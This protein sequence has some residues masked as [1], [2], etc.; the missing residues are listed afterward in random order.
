MPITVPRYEGAQVRETAI[1]GTRVS[2]DLP[3]AAVPGAGFD[4]AMAPAM[5]ML[6]KAKN[7]ADQLAIMEADKKLTQLET[8]L[9]YNKQTG[10]LN[11][12]GKDSFGTPDE[13][14][15]NY[16]KSAKDIEDSLSNPQQKMAFQRI[17]NDRGLSI[18]RTVQKHVA[19]EIK[20]YDDNETMAY[21][22]TQRDLA[23][24]A[25]KD[26]DKINQSIE[27]QKIAI[28]AHAQR[29]GMPP[30]WVKLKTEEAQSKTHTAV[31]ERM[32]GGG[33][34]MAAQAYFEANKQFIG[35]Q[36]S[37]KLEHDLKI[38][39]LAGESQRISDKIY[40]SGKSMSESIDEAKKIDDPKLRD[41]TIE[42]IKDN[43]N[44]K[45]IADRDAAEKTSMNFTNMIDQGSSI[46]DIM[47]KSPRQWAALPE[48]E[49]SSLKRYY[50]HAT[51]GKA[52]ETDYQQY[53]DLKTL[54]SSKE[55]KDEFLQT[56]IMQ[57]RDKLGNTELKELMALQAGMRK[58]DEKSQKQLD[59]YRTDKMIVDGA[60]AAAGFDTSLKGR[61]ADKVVKFQRMVDD[62]ITQLQDK[63]GKKANNA[64]VQ[65]ITDNLMIEVVTNKGF[66]WDT[67]KRAFELESGEDVEDLVIA[68]DERRK[69]EDALKR[70]GVQVSDKAVNEM[71]L[72]KMRRGNNA[73]K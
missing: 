58:G 24:T 65:K 53:Y 37:A 13:V 70:G 47:Q 18:D 44:L 50:E 43:F 56:N 54:A 33:E 17:A 4:K 45:K 36:E 39:T 30:E 28:A 2:T 23:I 71:Y 35:G 72:K 66:F 68:K 15:Q 12:R 31:V 38:S 9:L 42:R 10:A 21:V 20:A 61:D 57:Y 3:A 29:N 63:T 51:S 11:K 26:P 52:I 5:D 25:Y 69:I 32:I 73:S 22:G 48:S 60:L 16:S 62:Q 59:G 27:S 46:N 67:K 49:R 41:A 14:N 34:D 55:T 6:Q 40:A 7:D 1:T 64:D 8:D 19:G